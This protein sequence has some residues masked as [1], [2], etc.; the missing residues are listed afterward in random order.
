MP[1]PLPV[2]EILTVYGAA[3]C[4]DCRVACRFLESEGVP[5]RYIDLQQDP[6]AQELLARAGYSAIPVVVTTSGQILIE[7]TWQELA[8]VAKVA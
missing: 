7:P 4:G 2:P 3:W 8:A 6:A 1:S 5:Y